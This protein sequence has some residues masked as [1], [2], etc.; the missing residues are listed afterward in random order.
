MTRAL[1]GANS[2]RH[3]SWGTNGKY[4]ASNTAPQS[5]YQT[6]INQFWDS[7]I[8]LVKIVTKQ[9]LVR[10]CDDCCNI[11]HKEHFRPA[12]VLRRFQIGPGITVF[13]ITFCNCISSLFL[14]LQIQ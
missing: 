4:H 1:A 7:R 14:P 8:D 10:S 13:A 12:S 11:S 9:T 5:K 6:V 3:L 2:M